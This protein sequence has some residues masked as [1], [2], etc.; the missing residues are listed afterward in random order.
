MQH[1]CNL[2]KIVYNRHLQ[3][4]TISHNAINCFTIYYY[5]SQSELKVYLIINEMQASYFVL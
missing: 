2:I 4:A 3:I 5:T 1:S